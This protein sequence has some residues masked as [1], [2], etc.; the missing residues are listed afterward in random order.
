MKT[1]D[2]SQRGW[3]RNYNVLQ[4][5]ENGIR[6]RLAA[7]CTP[8]PMAGDFLILANGP[9]TTRYIVD[10]VEYASGVSDMTFLDVTFAPRGQ[11]A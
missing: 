6:L 10:A 2:L 5:V 1:I 7:W 8:S 3:G 11:V 9:D 4:V